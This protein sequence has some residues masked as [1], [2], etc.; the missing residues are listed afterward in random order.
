MA[1]SFFYSIFDDQ[2]VLICHQSYID[3]R[4]SDGTS[5]STIKN[6]VRL[7]RDFTKISVVVMSGDAH[8]INVL[9]ET[10]VN[11]FPSLELKNIKVEKVPG[12]DLY[13]YFGI[14]PHQE[15]LLRDLWHNHPLII[16]SFPALLAAYF[17]G[18]NVPFLHIHLEEGVIFLYVQK[19]GKMFLYNSFCTKSK[20][21]ILYFALATCQSTGLNPMT[22]KV[23]IS[24]WIE[25]DSALFQQLQGYIANIDIL[26]D[27][28][29]HLHTS[30]NESLKPH[31]Y[32]VHT[33]HAQCVS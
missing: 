17:I 33:I 15:N 14:S 3:I 32:F 20:T 12:Q 25:K 4:F 22:D 13:N 24:G 19:E 27:A 11:Y 23:T 26:T 5:I 8:Q 10:L 16:R 18:P 1:D 28:Q 29:H 6:D 21:D 7:S 2:D 30:V 9:D 31:F